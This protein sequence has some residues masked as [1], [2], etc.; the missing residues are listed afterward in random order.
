MLIQRCK[1]NH[2]EPKYENLKELLI[3]HLHRGLAYLNANPEQI[4]L[5]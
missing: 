3:V 2:L 1:E 4:F 5:V